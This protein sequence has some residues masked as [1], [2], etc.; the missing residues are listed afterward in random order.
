MAVTR[1]IRV[2]RAGSELARQEL[3]LYRMPDGAEAAKWGGLV[4]PL[5][6]GDSIDISDRGLPPAQCR[7]WQDEAPDL[8][9][10][11]G[12][13]G[14]ASYVFVEGSA[15]SCQSA[16]RRLTDAGFEVLRSGPNLSGGAGDW[17]IRLGAM[18]EGGQEKL[19]DLLRDV[20]RDVAISPP[21]EDETPLRERLLVQAL[22]ASQAGRV[23]LQ[24]ELEQAR[25]AAASGSAGAQDRDTL[26]ASLDAMAARLAET[27]AEAAFLRSRLAA[28]PP[29]TP[30][31][32]RLEVELGVA[33]AALLPR[34][35]FIGNSMRFIAVEV[36]ER[37]TLWRSLAVLDRQERGLPPAWKSLSGHPGWWER[38]FSTGQDN[39]GRIYARATGASS[40]WQVLVSHKQDQAMDLRRISRM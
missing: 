3:A 14:G 16:V 23:R 1:E 37:D 26:L 21:A 38:H 27:E 5:R 12:R 24:A 20:L 28:A 7:P 25:N 9:I 10:V 32:N 11:A 35:D 22:T 15:R 29:A 33:A 18:P 40:R 13:N 17:F 6:S 34:L 30:K 36:P 2:I 31:A 4:F 39:Q 8:D 19:P